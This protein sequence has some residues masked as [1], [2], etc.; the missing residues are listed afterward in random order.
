[1]KNEIINTINELAQRSYNHGASKSEKEE[2][3]QISILL[4][5]VSKS[6]ENKNYHSLMKSP[7]M[8]KIMAS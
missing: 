3:K 4:K 5:C 8:I 7:E 2:M 1:M 6:I